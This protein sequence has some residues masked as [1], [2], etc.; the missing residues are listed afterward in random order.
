MVDEPNTTE[1]A[2]EESDVDEDKDL[3][4]SDGE[5]R[6]LTELEIDVREEPFQ[7][8]SIVRKIERGHLIMAPD[9][10]RKE[11]WKL[12]Q[13]S[14]FIES[15]LLNYPLPPLYLN[16]DRQGRY[17]VVDGLQRTSSIF[18]FIQD[19]FA[20]TGLETLAWLNGKKFSELGV[21]LQSRIEDRK[22]NCYVI[23]RTVPLDV[24]YNIFARINR[25]GVALNRQEIRHGLYQGN[26]TTLL[27]RLAGS[28]PFAGWLGARMRPNRMG[29]EEAA[30]RCIAFARPDAGKD[31]RGNMDNF[32]VAAMQQLNRADEQ[33]LQ[34]IA[35]DF[36]RVFQQALDVL[37][38]DAFRIPTNK[39]RGRLNLA[40]ME[41][42]YRFFQSHEKE[43]IDKNQ[44]QIKAHYEDLM[45]DETYLDAVRSSTSDTNK[46]RVRF[47]VAETY[48][49]TDCV[50]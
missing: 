22:L 1:P 8:T 27:R 24:V 19:E 20:L 48:L 28:N 34:K 12:E 21:R 2:E 33:Q 13:R 46:V 11:V 50:D 9:F 30:L 44:R 47:E 25:G 15:I 32:L 35:D 26:A 39:T 17:I 14:E 16:E 42:V 23:K 43:W 29:D 38:E 6:D 3:Y 49:V 40:V 7:I 37:G 45:K 4:S 5:E 10:Q 36:V 18:R 31:Y 41:S